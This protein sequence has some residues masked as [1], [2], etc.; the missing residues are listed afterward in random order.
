MY[1][2]VNAVST[3]ASDAGNRARRAR[4]RDMCVGS[5][6]RRSSEHFSIGTG[7][8]RRR[9]NN[10]N[11]MSP[12]ANTAMPYA[13]KDIVAAPGRNS[14]TPMTTASTATVTPPTSAVPQTGCGRSH[15]P[16]PSS[17][18]ERENEKQHE[19]HQLHDLYSDQRAADHAERVGHAVLAPEHEAH[20]DPERCDHSSEV[21]PPS[22]HV[23]PPIVVELRVVE[24]RHSTRPTSDV[25]RVASAAKFAAGSARNPLR[26][27]PKRT[28]SAR[29]RRPWR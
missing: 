8:S 23:V 29:G 15:E 19:Q 2:A 1:V 17:T 16:P 27:R 21:C 14:S 12:A 10:A 28:G 7:I 9:A 18:E 24:P 13:R 20:D 4:N 22:P 6:S 5:N 11:A 3:G 26:C 25:A